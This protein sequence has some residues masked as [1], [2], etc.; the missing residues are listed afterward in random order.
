M[1]S[2]SRLVVVLL[3][4][5]SWAVWCGRNPLLLLCEELS[6]NGTGAAVSTARVTLSSPQRSN[7]ASDD[8][9]PEGGI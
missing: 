9:N 6:P 5:S 8:T 3:R 1:R 4:S 7:R 2:V